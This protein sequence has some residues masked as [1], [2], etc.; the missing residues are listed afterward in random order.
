[1]AGLAFV[2]LW[3]ALGGL[4]HFI[5]TDMAVR[6]V[7]PWLP[8]ARELVLFSGALEWLGAAGLLFSGTRRWAGWGLCLLTAAVTPVHVYMLQQPQQ[9]DIPLWALILRLPLQAAL[10]WLIW[11]STSTGQA[12]R[13]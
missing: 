13:A 4:G 10:L 2:F 5:A 11:W 9:W 3:F 7:P 8:H 12:A 6:L 1:V